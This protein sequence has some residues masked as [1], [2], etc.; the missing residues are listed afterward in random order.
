MKGGDIMETNTHPGLKLID[1][2]D[3]ALVIV[4]VQ[5][6][7]LPFIFNKDKMVENIVIL[8]KT[9]KI[10]DL[11]VVVTEQEK[12][13]ETVQKIKNELPVD[14]KQIIRKITYS[15][16][17]SLSFVERLRAINKQNLILTGME[18][19]I[20]IMQTALHGL[21]DFNVHVIS[22]AVSSRF[23]NNW[24]VALD[25][26]RDCGVVIST[27]EMVIFELLRQSGTD[28]FRAILPLV[29]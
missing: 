11:P 6:K 22:D 1:S 17:S 26:M 8:I 9:A 29:R 28:E 10:L 14:N 24:T 12:L 27:T 25:R 19:H 13:G 5:D 20:C 3:S 23:V 16:F 7:L 18:T 2:K 4:D 21:S 15:C